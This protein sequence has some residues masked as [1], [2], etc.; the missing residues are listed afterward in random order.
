MCCLWISKGIKELCKQS[1]KDKQINWKIF[2][3]LQKSCKFNLNLCFKVGHL[4]WNHIWYGEH[5]VNYYDCIHFV[6]FI[7]TVVFSYNS[8]KT[9]KKTEITFHLHMSFWALE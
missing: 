4:V 6:N 5:G 8:M 3:R 9:H 2:E 1:E 7:K